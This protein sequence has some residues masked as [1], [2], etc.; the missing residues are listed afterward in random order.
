MRLYC[1][2]QIDRNL[3][4]SI[5]SIGS[6][7]GLFVVNSVGDWKGKKIAMILALSVGIIGVL[8]SCNNI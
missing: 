3:I 2:G 1:D 7:I 6:V 8:C 4:Q 5:S